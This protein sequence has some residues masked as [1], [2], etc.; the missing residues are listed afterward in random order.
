MEF[1]ELRRQ[2]GELDSMSMK[3]F[4]RWLARVSAY[5]EAHPAEAPEPTTMIATHHSA[6]IDN[7]FM[8]QS[9]TSVQDP[10]PEDQTPTGDDEA[11][12][13]GPD[14]QFHGSLFA[15]V[16]DTYLLYL[17]RKHT[18]QDDQGRGKCDWTTLMAD[19]NNA[20]PS[21]T[22]RK[23]LLQGRVQRLYHA[24]KHSTN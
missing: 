12:P 5:D 16:H 13:P 10:G 15:P 11:P 14:N 8:G 20:Y 24:A 18:P 2:A 7:P 21:N 22:R 17:V 9:D 3:D 19:Y 6:H 1:Q 4:N 23:N